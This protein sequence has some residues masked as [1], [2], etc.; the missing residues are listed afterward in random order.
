[1]TLITIRAMTTGK[2]IPVCNESIHFISCTLQHLHVFKHLKYDN[3]SHPPLIPFGEFL[4]NLGLVLP[5]V[6]NQMDD[7]ELV[8]F[9]QP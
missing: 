6:Q 7:L 8:T 2:I 4:K 3:L 1:M 5:Q 9:S